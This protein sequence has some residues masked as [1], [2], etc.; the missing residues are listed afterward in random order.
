VTEHERLRQQ[1]AKAHKAVSNK[2][3]R[4]KRNTGANVAGSEFDPRR[5]AGTENRMRNTG[6][7]TE[8]LRQ[9]QGFMSR[10]N[11][12][13][14]GSHGAPLP[15]AYFNKIY[16]PT[17]R[18]LDAVQDARDN[19][20]GAIQG[21][22]GYTIKQKNLALPTA[23]GAAVYGPYK[24]FDRESTDIASFSAMKKLKADMANQMKPTYLPGKIN[25]ERERLKKVTDYLGENGTEVADAV[26]S[27]TDYE[28]DLFW[29]G[30][31]VASGVFLF[32]ELEKERAEGTHK[33][34]RQDRVIESKFA[35]VLPAVDWAKS[36][37]AKFAAKRDA[38]IAKQQARLKK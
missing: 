31:T 20:I 22:Q 18:A 21:P 4:T 6:N 1:I 13:V 36:E 28:F 2:I 30:T 38:E 23:G 11:Q 12:F 25:A 5:K 15:K 7:M 14:S 16:K 10:S 34:R 9:L 33:E 17:E 3:A 27:M 29:F 37:G 19:T 26:D 35:E 32:Y 24:R 8:Y